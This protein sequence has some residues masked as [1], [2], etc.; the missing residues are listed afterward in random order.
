FKLAIEALSTDAYPTASAVLP[1]IHVLL[2]QLKRTSEGE[3]TALLE[4]MV[5]IAADLGNRYDEVRG[6]HTL[7]NKA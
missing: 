7:L 2:A 3:A 5:R 1:I 6:A 4:M